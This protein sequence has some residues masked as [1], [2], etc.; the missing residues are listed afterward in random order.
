MIPAVGKQ[1]SRGAQTDGLRDLRAP[2]TCQF[3]RAERYPDSKIGQDWTPV[4]VSSA[5]GKLIGWGPSS[6]PI[7]RREQ[8]GDN[9]AGPPQQLHQYPPA[10]HN[11]QAQRQVRLLCR[12]ARRQQCAKRSLN[13]LTRRSRTRPGKRCVPSAALAR[14]PPPPLQRGSRALRFWKE[15][16]RWHQPAQDQPKKQQDRSSF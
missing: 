9:A 2:V 13:H 15:Q 1:T 5:V 10:Q 6:G 12:P 11:H 7:C 14:T 8:G 4:Q 3:Q 16:E